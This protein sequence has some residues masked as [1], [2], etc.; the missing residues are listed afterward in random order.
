MKLSTAALEAA[1]LAMPQEDVVA[2]VRALPDWHLWELVGESSEL[3]QALL[4]A[5]CSP[6]QD[7]PRAA[8]TIEAAPYKPHDK[9]PPGP[10]WPGPPAELEDVGLPAPPPL[11]PATKTRRVVMS[12]TIEHHLRAAPDGL[13]G[14]EVARAIGRAQSTALYHLKRLA[15]QDRAHMRGRGRRVRWHHG[16]RVGPSND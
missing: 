7:V 8:A 15:A 2:A 10:P 16:R 9:L 14:S 13:T 11:E 12:A 6:L 3:R 5:A 1:I 4:V